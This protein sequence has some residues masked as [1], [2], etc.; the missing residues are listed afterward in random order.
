MTIREFTWAIDAWVR[1]NP[2]PTLICAALCIVSLLAY[3]HYHDTSYCDRL[4]T[5]VGVLLCHFH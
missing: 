4:Q 3:T 1:Q 5:T 2:K